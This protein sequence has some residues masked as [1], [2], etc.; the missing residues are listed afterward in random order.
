MINAS[1]CLFDFGSTE[2]RLQTNLLRCGELA[3]VVGGCQR[4][5]ERVGDPLPDPFKPF[6][7]SPPLAHSGHAEAEMRPP[8]DGVCRQHAAQLRRRLVLHAPVAPLVVGHERRRRALNRGCG[9]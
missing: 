3:Q 8:L 7:T 1:W 4:S 6:P 2:E 9:G 5:L